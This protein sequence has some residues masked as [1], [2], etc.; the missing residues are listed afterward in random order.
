MIDQHAK[1]FS[2]ISQHSPVAQLDEAT[3]LV[4]KD[5]NI[6][7]IISIGGGSP[8]DSAKAI[9]SRVQTKTAKLLFHITIP[10]TISA[11]EC[12]AGAGYTAYVSILDYN[13]HFM[14]SSI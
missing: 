7:T 14:M 6:D 10:T 1:T 2:R 9:T 11:A 5:A 4:V 13:Y 8:I 3:D 12:T